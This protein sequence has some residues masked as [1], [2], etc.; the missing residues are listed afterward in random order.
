MSRTM[1]LTKNKRID[2]NTYSSRPLNTLLDTNIRLVPKY[3]PRFLDIEVSLRS[4][5]INP[6]PRESR[7]SLQKPRRPLAHRPQEQSQS[8]PN[9]DRPTWLGDFVP[10]RGPNSTE[11]VPNVERLAVRDE[12]G[13]TCDLERVRRFEGDVLGDQ[14]VELPSNAGFS[15]SAFFEVEIGFFNLGRD[16]ECR[17]RRSR[18][19]RWDNVFASRE[20]DVGKILL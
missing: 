5:I 10:E 6:A 20:G 8:S 9:R 7:L 18:F 4:N 11:E 15:L 16:S 13:L 3:P 14:G 19:A 1:R 17:S 12:E 2:E